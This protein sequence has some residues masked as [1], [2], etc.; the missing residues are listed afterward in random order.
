MKAKYKNLDSD[1]QK[2][3]G[4]RPEIVFTKK[5][6]AKVEELS[7]YLNCEQISDYFGISHTAFQDIRTR[8]PEVLLAYK[9]GK[10]HKIYD[11]A[12]K[13]ENKAMG[14][15]ETGDTTSIIFYLKTQAGW[16]EKQQHEITTKGSPPI[17]TYVVQDEKEKSS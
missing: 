12:K 3:K 2:N 14:I 17:L 1:K 5:Q 16:S 9:K 7:A 15:D 11:Y 6:T 10:A 4:G 8:Q 13:L